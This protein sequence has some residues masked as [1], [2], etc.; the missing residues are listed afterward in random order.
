MQRATSVIRKPAVKAE[1][2]STSS[3]WTTRAAT[4]AA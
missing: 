2:S 1:R 3:C 4:G